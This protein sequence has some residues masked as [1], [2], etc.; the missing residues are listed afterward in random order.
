MKHFL[1]P[2]LD[3][4]AATLQHGGFPLV[5]LLMW[6]ESSAVPLPSEFI[7]PP[8][9]HLGWTVGLPLFGTILI[10]WPA[11]VALIVAGALGS[12]AGASVVYWVARLAGR[13]LILRY[14]RFLMIS[15]EKVAG[16]VWLMVRGC[17]SVR[18]LPAPERVFRVIYS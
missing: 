8:A 3:W 15:P 4:Y 11:M 16:A 13:P 5:A 2:I 1:Q 6:V 10:G 7:I 9:A 18:M 17:P 12:W 14:G